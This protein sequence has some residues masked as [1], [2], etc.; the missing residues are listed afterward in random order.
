MDGNGE[1][2]DVL[3]KVFSLKIAGADDFLRLGEDERIVCRRINIRWDDVLHEFD[4]VVREA[5]DNSDI[6]L[7]AVMF[8]RAV[9]SVLWR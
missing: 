9:M 5:I 7:W 1:E 6:H 3:S 2:I 8:Y 4:G